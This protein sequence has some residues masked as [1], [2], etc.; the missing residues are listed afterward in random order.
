MLVDQLYK[1]NSQTSPAFSYSLGPRSLSQQ[2]QV[3]KL[4]ANAE[5]DT[6]SIELGE[7]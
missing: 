6:K 4:K 7:A 5:T 3:V 1:A 2:L